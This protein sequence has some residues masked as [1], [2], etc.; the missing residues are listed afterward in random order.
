MQKK[1][2]KILNVDMQAKI[3]QLQDI[4]VLKYCKQ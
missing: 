1:L 3:L 4:N 2:L